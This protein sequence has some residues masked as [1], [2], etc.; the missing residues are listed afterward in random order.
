MNKLKFLPL[1]L[2]FLF[3]HAQ[4][5][6]ESYLASL[7]DDIREDLLERNDNKKKRVRR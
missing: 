3:I 7:P 5:L 2:P 4:E 6:D 1:L